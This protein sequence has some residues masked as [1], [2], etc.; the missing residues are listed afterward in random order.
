MSKES[1]AKTIAVTILSIT[2]IIVG[3]L[4]YTVNTSSIY[5]ILL[6]IGVVLALIVAQDLIK[7]NKEK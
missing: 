5:V 6:F 4:F 3:Y 1:I 2:F 7:S